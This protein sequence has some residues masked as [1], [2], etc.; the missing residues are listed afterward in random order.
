[1][2]EHIYYIG[3]STHD[4]VMHSKMV[5]RHGL[6]AGATGTGKTVSLKVIA[7]QLSASGVPVFLSDVKGDLASCA[8]KG[9]ANDKLTARINELQLKDFNFESFPIRLWDVFGELGHPLRTSISEMG[10]LLLSRVL[11]LND[12][13]SGVLHVVFR[14]ADDLGFLLIDLK[15][16][17]S[18]LQYVGEHANEF[19]LEYGSVSKTSVGAITRALLILED[20]G[21]N[22]FFG[23]PAIDIED[24]IQQDVDG[25]GFINVLSAQKLMHSPLLYSTFLL[26]L[27]SELYERLPEVGDLD[28]PKLVFFFDEAHIL[29]NDISKTLLDKIEMVVRLIRSKGVGV[30]FVTQNPI[31]I[32]DSVLS[33]LGNRIQHSLRSFT[34]REQKAVNAMAETFRQNPDLDINQVITE[35]KTGEALVS[36]LELDG[37]PSI[38]QRTLIA[39]PRSLIGVLEEDKYQLFIKNSPFYYKY[40]DVV[41]K[42]SAYELLKAKVDQEAQAKQEAQKPVEQTYVEPQEKVVKEK[43]PKAA[44]AKKQTSELQKLTKSFLGTMSSSIG[45]ELARGVFGSLKRK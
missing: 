27:L 16:L 37:K 38:V 44:P 42:E 43:T 29:F 6:I 34:P 11:D 40:K 7:E 26:Y 39:P 1:M 25:R 9:Q 13:Q 21:G 36:M 33:Q 45:R 10:P 35:L 23:E 22:N 31:D 28:Q 41:D 14:V 4:V 15:D 17:R 8:I 32:P 18:M 19:T 12:V 5:N 20:Q 2:S 24:F 3:R 30:F